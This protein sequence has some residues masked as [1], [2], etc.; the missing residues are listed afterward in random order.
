METAIRWSPTSTLSEQHFLIADVKDRF[1]KRCRV[2]KYDGNTFRHE[3]ISTHSKVPGFRAFD[4]APHDESLVAVGSWSGE[5]TILHIDNSSPNISLPAKRQRL[6]NAVAFNR[7][8]LLAAGLE[9]IRND[10]CLNIW[11]VN[12]RLPAVSS[13]RDGPFKPSVEPYRRFASSEAI[14]SIKFFGGQPETFV[15]GIKGKGIRIY[16]LRESTGNPSLV[17]K[18]DSVFNIAID[19]LH[20]NYFA[21]ASPP[22]DRTIQI[23]DCRAGAPYST[24]M[25]GSTLDLGFQAEKPVLEYRDVFKPQKSTANRNDGTGVMVSTIWSLRYCKGKSG[26]LGAL[27]STGDFKV[28]ETKHGYTPV[29]KQPKVDEHLEYGTPTTGDNKMLTKRIHHMEYAFDDV[30]KGR[31]EKERIVAFDFTNLASSKGTPS[32]IVLRGDQTIDIVELDGAPPALSIST[33]GDI[34]LSRPYGS[35]PRS[36]EPPEESNFLSMA[37]QR[38]HPREDGKIA[39]ILARVHRDG[40]GTDL[41]ATGKHT[42][43][44]G[45]RMSSRGLHEQLLGVQGPNPKLTFRE[46]LALFTVTRRR[47]S[48]GYLFDC[49]KNI[50]ILRD[51]PWLQRLWSWIDSAYLS[52]CKE[53]LL[54][55]TRFTERC[56]R[57]GHDNRCPGS[58]LLWC[59][60]YLE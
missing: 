12:Q 3:T 1:F 22:D 27:A 59:G 9:G 19:P 40:S 6:C 60:K 25:M 41:P 18:T 51:D 31:P 34:V 13:P 38:F 58:Q 29:S 7:T 54:T 46:T 30:Q 16:D 11:D 56:Q 57:R 23:W 47:C 17:F 26:C 21:C 39:E 53:L 15:A 5:V 10:F 42:A 36:Q 24:T 43:A 52:A 37:V 32:L 28:F 35:F 4:W 50:E 55:K 20:E 14:S 49:K 8:G 2:E 33:F 48:E 44:W 45:Q